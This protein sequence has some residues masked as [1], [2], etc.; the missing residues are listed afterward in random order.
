MEENKTGTRCTCK[1]GIECEKCYY[2]YDDDDC[3]YV[4]TDGRLK[5]G[6]CND[7]IDKNENDKKERESK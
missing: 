6:L 5:K 7:C 3:C 2:E 4:F 1:K